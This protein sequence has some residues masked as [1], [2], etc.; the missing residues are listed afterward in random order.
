MTV[1]NQMVGVRSGH[2]ARTRGTP[3]LHSK[4]RYRHDRAGH[5]GRTVLR[6]VRKRMFLAISGILIGNKTKVLRTREQTAREI[7]LIPRVVASQ[8]LG[9]CITEKAD[10]KLV[11]LVLFFVSGEISFPLKVAPHGFYGTKH[12]LIFFPVESTAVSGT[13]CV[14]RLENFK[15]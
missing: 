11:L 7:R 13:R 3:R 15:P 5:D 6:I 8:R 10:L 9:K 14:G 2:W 1:K 4:L 12:R